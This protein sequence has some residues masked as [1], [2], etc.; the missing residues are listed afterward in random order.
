VTGAVRPVAPGLVGGADGAPG[1]VLV[2]GTRMAGAYWHAQIVSLADRFRVVAPDLPGHGARRAERFSPREALDTIV[3]A[4]DGCAGGAAVVVGHSLGGFLVMDVAAEVPDRCRGL[5][6]AGSTALARGPRTWPYRALAGVLPLLPEARLARWNDRLLRRLY[7]AELVEP[8]IA[9]GY[10]FAAVPASWRAVLGRDHRVA[11][12]AY[13]GPVLFL[14]GRRDVL[15]RSGERR[16]LRAC[17]RARLRLLDGAGHLS[18][19]DRPVEFTAAV[20]AFAA[21]VYGLPPR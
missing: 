21:S 8:Q 5:V 17:P 16:Y 4:I 9:A 15:F 20:R 12:A 1:I 3:R 11:L 10:G 7:P 6:L 13:P 18:S 14:N 2:H 19:L